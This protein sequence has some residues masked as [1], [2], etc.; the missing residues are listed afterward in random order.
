M[1]WADRCW[2]V[3]GGLR[4]I[5]VVATG[6]RG[7]LRVVRRGAGPRVGQKVGLWFARRVVILDVGA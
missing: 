6:L 4:A 2:G 1:F 5:S 7:E 3:S